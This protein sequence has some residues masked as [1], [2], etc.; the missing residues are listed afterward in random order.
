MST[1]YTVTAPVEGRDGKT[2][3]RRVGVMFQQKDG[4]KSAFNIK[5][6]FPIGATE[7]VL[8]AP[9]DDGEGDVTE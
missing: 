1:Y 8:F 3:F 2:R 6:D 9:S 7:L 5:L 4:A